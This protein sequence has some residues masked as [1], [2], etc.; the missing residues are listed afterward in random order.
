[1]IDLDV[2][3]TEQYPNAQVKNILDRR[4]HQAYSEKLIVRYPGISRENNSGHP[5]AQN[6]FR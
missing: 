6:Y 2:C 4:R 3:V 5:D 1:M